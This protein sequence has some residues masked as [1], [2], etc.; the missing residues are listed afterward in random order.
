MIKIKIQVKGGKVYDELDSSP[1]SL[2]ETALAIHRLEQIKSKLLEKDFENE[3][4]VEG[5]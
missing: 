1:C 2:G 4:Y 5:L 3:V